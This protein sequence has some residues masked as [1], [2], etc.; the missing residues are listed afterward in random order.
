MENSL[1][2]MVETSNEL[3]KLEQNFVDSK[4]EEMN[5]KIEEMKDNIVS[6]LIEFQRKRVK[7]EK[8]NKQGEP[9]Q[10][11]VTMNP[12]VINNM[13]FKSVCP[14][15]SSEPLYNAEKLGLV[16]DY[17]CFILAE[18]NDKVG[19]YPSS[20]TSFCKL[21]GISSNTLRQYRNSDDYNM[22]I[23]AEKIYDQISDENITMGQLGMAKERTTLFK[24]RSQNEMTEAERPQVKININ[25][26]INTDDIESKL[27]KYKRFAQ[28]RGE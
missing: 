11:G 9:I 12:L 14:I 21:A 6:Q 1:A 15:S 17:Y 22:R 24:L 7:P 8:W 10:F 5:A 16:Y 27:E 28:K 20:L 3:R 19:S 4:I 18:I 23:I 13:F 2:T 26:Q 25:E